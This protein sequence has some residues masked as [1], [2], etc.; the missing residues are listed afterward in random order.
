MQNLLNDQKI[1]KS[2]AKVDKVE[3]NTALN[4]AYFF[5]KKRICGLRIK[6]V[7]DGS[8]IL[9]SIK[10]D[11]DKPPRQTEDGLKDILRGHIGYLQTRQLI[12]QDVPLFPGYFGNS[13]E[14][15]L[16]RHISDYSIHRDFNALKK[17][18]IADQYNQP[19]QSG[20]NSSNQIKAI[21]GS[22]GKSERTIARSLNMTPKPS[23][24]SI[25][26]V[27]KLRGNDPQQQFLLMLDSLV[28]LPKSQALDE[29]EVFEIINKE[30]K[31]ANY[32]FKD[33]AVEK[34]KY[35]LIVAIDNRVSEIEKELINKKSIS[36]V[37]AKKSD[38]VDGPLKRLLQDIIIKHNEVTQQHGQILA[39]ESQTSIYKQDIFNGDINQTIKGVLNI[40][41]L[42]VSEK[43]ITDKIN[44]LFSRIKQVRSMVSPAAWQKWKDLEASWQ[45]KSSDGNIGKN[46]EA[47]RVAKN[48]HAQQN[49]S[50]IITF[51]RETP[52]EIKKQKIKYVKEQV[53]DN[54]P[55]HSV[56]ML[57]VVELIK[58]TGI[59]CHEVTELCIRNVVKTVHYK[60]LID[61]KIQI[62]WIVD[63]IAPLLMEYP[64]WC[65]KLPIPLTDKAK[66]II[67]GEI[68]F[69]Q[70]VEN[71]YFHFNI[72]SPLFPLTL[73][74]SSFS[75]KE[76]KKEEKSK[77]PRQIKTTPQQRKMNRLGKLLRENHL[78]SVGGYERLREDGIRRYYAQL[79]KEGLPMQDVIRRVQ[80]FARYL[81][82]ED[83]K[84][85][86]SK[87]QKQ[88]I[89]ALPQIP[90]DL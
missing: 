78:L 88:N 3:L 55:D 23:T 22:T 85:I 66:E 50:Q 59:F 10:P 6:D 32:A 81:N 34:M 62:D 64:K 49:K 33:Q 16:Q 7:Y 82:E 9:S 8:N 46:T 45:V 60:K 40:P 17:A 54:A 73:S 14:K 11:A 77:K 61:E 12:D 29:N 25:G 30:F 35:W 74:A 44:R 38:E 36:N 79:I 87:M 37:P 28:V 41:K 48:L 65:I 52:S 83:A 2:K 15:K 39:D 21:A 18:L 70:G 90:K 67:R 47:D 84:R 27:K 72:R 4:L 69:L 80:R 26:H 68:E 51:I 53:R 89:N 1:E 76:R 13:G 75:G 43:I 86:I 71:P 5:S 20:D 19:A 31:I 63:E 42:E 24:G 57:N 58:H 56:V